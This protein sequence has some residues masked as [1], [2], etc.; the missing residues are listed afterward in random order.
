MR[1]PFR[2]I[3]VPLILL[4]GCGYHFSGEGE[5]P[6]PGLRRISIPV[7][8]NSTSE[9]ELGSM[10]A[11][12]LRKQFLLRGDLQVVPRDEAEVV[13]KGRITDIYTSA[14]AHRAFEQRYQTRLTLEARLYITLDIRCE[15]ARTGSV[16]WRDSKFTE[17]RVFGQNPD[18]AN[19]DPILTF[20][21]RRLAL[22]YLARDMANQI[23]DRFMSNF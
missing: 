16:I 20:D 21:N 22:E 4:S 2:A 3:I 7:F 23:H 8:E 14:V 12:E 15:D 10:F 6:R 18:P 17:S 5:G 11:G 9:P 1:R 19:P 13:F